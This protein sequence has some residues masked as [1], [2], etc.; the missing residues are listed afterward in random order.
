[1]ECQL[2]QLQRHLKIGGFEGALH[3]AF[4]FHCTGMGGGRLGRNQNWAKGSLDIL[5]ASAKPP[6]REV[7]RTVTSGFGSCGAFGWFWTQV[8]GFE[9]KLSKD[10]IPDLRGA[11]PAAVSL[12]PVNAEPIVGAVPR[13]CQVHFY[14]T[15][16][17]LWL[18][19]AEFA[20]PDDDLRVL[21]VDGGWRFGWPSRH[22]LQA[23]RMH[24]LFLL[25]GIS[26][27][28]PCPF[29]VRRGEGSHGHRMD[30]AAAV[31][32][33]AMPRAG[34]RRDGVAQSRHSM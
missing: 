23:H 18:E 3:G 12:L 20:S 21:T 5:C 1:M 8:H 6:S 24:R 10:S 2:V 32:P 17:L 7:S 11:C 25:H 19:A 13:E 28:C 30:A 29:A 31:H 9:A 4:D 34:R 15:R 26:S 22:F 16:H 27:F 33:F 14:C